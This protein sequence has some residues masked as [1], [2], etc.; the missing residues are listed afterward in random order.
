MICARC[1]HPEAKH[2]KGNI[3]HFYTYKGSREVAT[4]CVGRHCLNP[5]C[6]CVAFVAPE[7]RAA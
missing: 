4:T 1:K 7:S 5:L 6:S 2:C 3:E